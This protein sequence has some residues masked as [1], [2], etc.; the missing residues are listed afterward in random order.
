MKNVYVIGGEKGGTGKS[1]I[2]TNLAVMS[3]RM[4]VETILVD[5]DKQMSSRNFINYRNDKEI[6]PTPPCIQLAGNKLHVELQELSNKYKRVIVDVG[7]RDSIEFRSSIICSNVGKIYSPIAPSFFD[8]DTLTR[9]D[10]LVS[11][12][13]TYNPEIE[14]YIVMNNC[15]SHP[16]VTVSEEATSIIDEFENL[17]RTRT[18]LCSR[19]I[20]QYAASAQMSVVEYENMQISKKPEYQLKSY[21]PKASLEIISLYNEIFEEEFS[22]NTLKSLSKLLETINKKERERVG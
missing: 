16:K 15:S 7:G 14:M 21:T 19:Q 5:A 22:T 10:D 20:Y 2:A 17:K 9:L 1:T 18:Q 8:V 3:S 6:T 13:S 4:G 11:L 12:S